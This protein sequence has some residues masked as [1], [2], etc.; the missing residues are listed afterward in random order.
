MTDDTLSELGTDWLT[1]LNG[2][3]KWIANNPDH[4]RY[5]DAI[6]FK[7]S[8]WDR[9][10]FNLKELRMLDPD[11]IRLNRGIPKRAII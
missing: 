4:S 8:G 7:D 10:Q 2:L 1:L 9:R 3:E 11:P 6:A 5:S